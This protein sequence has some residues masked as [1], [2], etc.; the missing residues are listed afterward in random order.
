M[1]VTYK[2]NIPVP[3]ENETNNSFYF[4]ECD[5]VS[6]KNE[7]T[8]KIKVSF[9]LIFIFKG[10]GIT[11][12]YTLRDED[13]HFRLFREEYSNFY[14]DAEKEGELKI[15][16]E[17]LDIKLDFKIVSNALRVCQDKINEFIHQVKIEDEKN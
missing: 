3:Q 16:D 9:T 17:N 10:P 12:K 11:M 6:T 13:A 5:F 8:S 2:L 4:S 15:Y 14:S 7:T 1:S